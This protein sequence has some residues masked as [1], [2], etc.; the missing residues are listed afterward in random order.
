[1]TG[2]ICE[3]IRSVVTPEVDVV[4]CEIGGTVGDIESLPFL[5][6]LRIF[7]YQEGRNNCF[8]IHVTLIPYLDKA[9]EVKTKP[10][11]HS[12]GRLREIGIIPDMLVCRT[13]VH[14]EKDV[15]R[16]FRSSATSTRR[17]WSRPWTWTIPSMKCRLNSQHRTSTT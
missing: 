10:T 2:E 12:V 9:G 16:R 8:F 5:E 4:I 7:R 1:M 11:Q 17:R 6:A 13:E 3:S 15:R 14:L